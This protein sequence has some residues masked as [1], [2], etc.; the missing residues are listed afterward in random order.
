MSGRRYRNVCFTSFRDDI[1]TALDAKEDWISYCIAQQ[2][3]CP[4][5]H[6]KHW[7]GYLELN[8]QK[9]FRQLKDLFGDDAHLEPRQGTARQAADYCR[10]EDT[11]VAGT[12]F[13]IGEISNPGKRSDLKECYEMIKAGRSDAE[14]IDAYPGTYIRCYK[15]L[16]HVRDVLIRASVPSFRVVR[17]YV[18]YGP[19][20]TGKTRACYARDPGLYSLPIP[21]NNALWFDGYRAHKTLLLD[22]F[23]GWIKH[24]FLLRLLDGYP[25]DMPYKGG[26]HPA[27]W[28][29]VFITSNRHPSEWYSKHGLKPELIRR[30]SC[31][32][33]L[34]KLKTSIIE[35][36]PVAG[37]HPFDP[38]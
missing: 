24:A 3:E 36:Y 34:D 4:T 13:E 32:Y 31:C 8:G 25:V 22:D 18:F 9:S 2:E 33:H 27:A 21:A 28:E 37:T 6:R 35:L 5:T 7:Q 26:F 17:C 14:I 30:I 15:G 16:H 29:T 10:K 1:R 23:T 19:T 20:G 38:D 11:A 12:L